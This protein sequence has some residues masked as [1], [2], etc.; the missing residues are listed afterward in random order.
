VSA[1]L[2][3]WAVR[4][5]RLDDEEVARRFPQFASWSEGARPTFKQLESFARATHAPLGFFFLAEPPDEPVPIPDFRTMGDAVVAR[6]SPDLLDT[7]YACQMRQEWYRDYAVEQELDPL[8]FVGSVTTD[9]SPVLVADRIRHAIR[10][11]VD[12]RSLYSTYEDALR[13]LIDLIEAVGV[14]V[15]VSG[16]VGGNTHRKLDPEEFRGFALSDPFAPLIFVNGADTKAAQIFTMIHELAHI[17][18]GETA[19][20]D[21]AMARTANNAHE[22]WCNAVAAEVLVPM[23][24]LAIEYRGTPDEA[25]LNRLARKYRVSTLVVLRRIFD[26]QRLTWDDYRSLYEAELERILG[27]LEARRA[28]GSGGNFYYTQPLRISRRFARAVIVDALE[29]GTLYR[30]AYGLLGTAKRETFDN[31][32]TELGV[33]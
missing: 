6:P 9:D 16:I 28:T 15:M 33:A 13:A 24:S 26:A 1:E 31:L 19:L 8:A 14:L 12:E 23:S 11:G 18:L 2:L 4:R 32:A 10:F 27:I 21:A 3:N 30:D 17:Y 29:G 25:E 20:S 7:I 5:A 22:R